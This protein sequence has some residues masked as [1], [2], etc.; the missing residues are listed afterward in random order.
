MTA[1]TFLSFIVRMALLIGGLIITVDGVVTIQ[2]EGLTF[3]EMPIPYI[4][5]A[6]GIAILVLFIF[7]LA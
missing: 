6:I 4:K 7:L 5:T 3:R 2:T 1:V